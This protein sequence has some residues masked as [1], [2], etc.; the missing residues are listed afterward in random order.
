MGLTLQAACVT[1]APGADQVRL[2]QSPADVAS[3][4]PAGN[5]RVP[6]N[7]QTGTVDIAN[8]QR[9]FRNQVVGQGGNAGLVTSGLVGAPS[10]GIAYQCP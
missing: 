7:A 2:T 1:L 4:K 8:A 10:E 6:R 3:C 5:V 9:Q